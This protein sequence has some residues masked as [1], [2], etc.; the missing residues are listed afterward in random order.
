MHE[1]YEGARTWA[2]N[3]GGAVLGAGVLF[4]YFVIPRRFRTRAL[5]GAIWSVSA[6]AVVTG[7]V[8]YLAAPKIEVRLFRGRQAISV[9]KHLLWTLGTELEFAT[10]RES[11]AEAK[12]IVAE[13][14]KAPSYGMTWENTF[15]GGR[16]REEDSPGNYLLRPTTNGYDFLIYDPR[17]AEIIEAPLR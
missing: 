12:A 11:L 16:I 14:M 6:A 17:G 13:T 2:F 9:S 4:V 1:H 5:P 3:W 15:L 8:V 7:L 10:N